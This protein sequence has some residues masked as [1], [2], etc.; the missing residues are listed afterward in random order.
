MTLFKICMARI[1]HS[2]K[3]AARKPRQMM[4]MGSDNKFRGNVLIM[5][6]G[7]RCRPFWIYNRET[8]QVKNVQIK[9]CKTQKIPNHGRNS[10]SLF[11]IRACPCGV[12]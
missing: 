1:I 12:R 2:E 4:R 7:V 3:C 8:I 6:I 10:G 9:K 11:L 5:I